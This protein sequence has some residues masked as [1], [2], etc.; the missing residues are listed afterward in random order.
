MKSMAGTGVAGV[1]MEESAFL[2]PASLAFFTLGDV[3]VQRDNLQFKNSKGDIVQKAKNS[4]VV[5]ADGNASLSGSLSYT[6]QEEG[7]LKRSRWGLTASAPLNETS[8]FGTSIRKTTEKNSLTNTELGYYQTV[9]GVT[10]ALTPQTSL[11]VVAYDAFNSNAKETKAIIGVQQVFA[12]SIT[13]A[14]DFGGNYTAE[15][16][17]KTLLYRGGVQLR[18]LEDFYIR[19]GAF[20]DK[21]RQEKGNGYGIAWIQPKLAFEFALK[22]TK[23]S[24][25]L[26]LNRVESKLREVSF[27]ASLRF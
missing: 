25:D 24:A 9:I 23:Q 6:S 20:N 13:F 8:S 12:E 27:A 17:T 3:Y 1:Y 15:D 2:N 5:I 18:V 26:A 7:S 19:F 14:A 11:G 4:A 16:I 10:H 21:S 22:N